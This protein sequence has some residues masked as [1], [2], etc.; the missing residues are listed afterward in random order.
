[1]MKST[2]HKNIKS[3]IG[4]L[5]S[6]EVNYSYFHSTPTL[7]RSLKEILG[8][9][10]ETLTSNSL[11]CNLFDGLDEWIMIHKILSCNLSLL[12][13]V[14]FSSLNLDE[15]LRPKKKSAESNY[16]KSLVDFSE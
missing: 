13:H 7:M 10:L 5:R 16:R 1:M 11:F 15:G 9:L 6:L 4:S 14:E 12:I 3:V 8:D 2:S